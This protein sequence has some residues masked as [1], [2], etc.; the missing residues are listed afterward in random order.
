MQRQAEHSLRGQVAIVTGA[1]RGLGRQFA[2]SLAHGGANL[3][4]TARAQSDGQV[5]GFLSDTARELRELG[6][7]VAEVPADLAREEDLQRVVTAAV[8]RFGGVDILVNN[9]AVTHLGSWSN[10]VTEIP[11]EDWLYQFAVNI[12]APFF[13]T[14]LVLPHMERRGGGRII[15]ITAGSSDAYR[16][17]QETPFREAIGDFRMAAPAYF[18]TKRALDRLGNVIAPELE[19]KNIAVITLMPGMVA[20][21]ITQ[22][23]VENAGLD[24]SAL[25]PM[26]LPARLLTYFASCENPLEYSGQIFWA[27]RDLQALGID[28]P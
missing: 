7:D 26:T 9:A 11:R 17:P 15:N 21:E 5:P 1:S 22:R 14:Q 19:R 16:L 2:L 6:V 3:V 12:H 20:S 13:L 10:P 23:N 8:E 25:K 28:V 18:A 24:G 4:I 27:E